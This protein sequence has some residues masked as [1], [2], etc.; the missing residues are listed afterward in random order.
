MPQSWMII[1]VGLAYLG[2]LF[3]VAT[4]G[5]RP[6]N[7]RKPGSARPLIYALSLGVYCTS[8]TYFGS[9]GIASRSGFDFLPI[10]LGPILVFGLGWP[11]LQTVATIAKRQNIASIADFLSA[12]YGKS[13]SLG[14]LVTAIAVIGIVPYISIQ[15]KAV[16]TSLDTMIS[17]PL[18]P[19]G[20]LAQA[21]HGA[22]SLS[23]LVAITMGAFAILFGTRHIDTTEH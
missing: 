2:G 11:L 4:W 10:Y 6:A 1:F 5:D 17:G 7:R 18:W 20:V 13:E 16:A 21:G 12:R 14:A 23:V 22:D 19:G 8:W 15:L 3:A 9:V